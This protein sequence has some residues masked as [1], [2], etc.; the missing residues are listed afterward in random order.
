MER[1]WGP[2]GNGE[3]GTGVVVIHRPYGASTEKRYAA[4]SLR[5]CPPARPRPFLQPP[6]YRKPLSGNGHQSPRLLER[7]AGSAWQWR[8]L[9]VQHVMRYSCTVSMCHCHRGSQQTQVRFP[10][11]ATRTMSSLKNHYGGIYGKTDQTLDCFSSKD[12]QSR[13]LEP[14]WFGKSSFKLTCTCKY[15]CACVRI[16]SQFFFTTSR[17]FSPWKGL[18]V[19]SYLR[20]GN[21][22]KYFPTASFIRTLQS[23]NQF[24][25]HNPIPTV[26][27]DVLITHSFH[28]VLL[29][30]YFYNI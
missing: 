26:I 7:S 5:W 4:G 10:L 28:K 25:K 1:P 14:S 15:S 11:Q 27:S 13:I 20:Q 17:Q 22:G 24:H 29:Y 2:S 30:V 21:E 6:T 12:P 19:L 3:V 16:H 8:G 18:W 23:T 9:Q